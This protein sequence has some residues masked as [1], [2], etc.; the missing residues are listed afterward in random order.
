MVYNGRQSTYTSQGRL[1]TV[2]SS[3]TLVVAVTE[4]SCNVE[5]DGKFLTTA[6]LG[7]VDYVV[8]ENETKYKLGMGGWINKNAVQPLLGSV[9][10]QNS[11]SK[12]GFGKND[13]GEKFVFYGTKN[14]IATTS[15][16][17]DKLCVTLHHTDGLGNFAVPQTSDLFSSVSVTKSGDDTRMEFSLRPEAVL[18]GYLVEYNE[19]TVS[20][21]CK[22][23]PQLS[24]DSNRPLSGITVALDSG[25]GGYDP[26][27]LGIEQTQGPAEKDINYATALA[28]KKRLESL[29]AQVILTG[30]DILNSDFVTRMKPGQDTRADLFISLHSNAIG[31]GIDGT[32]V[33]G[34][35]IY[36]YEK[37][38]KS[39][40]DTLM[41][42]LTASTG[43]TNRGVKADYYRV[44]LNSCAPSVL[45]EMGFVTNP[46]EYD[47]L[48]SR[49]GIFKTA[50]AIGD[51][52]VAY[53]A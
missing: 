46:Q 23:K 24:A 5:A 1:Y 4:V 22:Y 52:I 9:S 17:A 6:K 43:R 28:V 34:I 35:E 15:Q 36:Y 14:A 10:W 16:S 51:A 29:G 48:C 45:V 19:G 40:G 49:D 18:W 27:A 8:D 47:S 33:K 41:S 37:I 20:L 50:N 25:H 2:G 11:V 26:G 39:F 42:A 44:T 3:S 30:G 12:I 31:E 53:F 32:K 7:A 13:A 21:Y 38:A